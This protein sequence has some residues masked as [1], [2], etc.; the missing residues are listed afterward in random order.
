MGAPKGIPQHKVNQDAYTRIIKALMKEPQT[1][2]SLQELTGL[3]RVTLQRLFRT[4]RA[5][6]IV[7]ISDWEQDRRGA[8]AF[9][10]FTLGKGKDKP[11]YKM[12]QAERA[13][14]WRERKKLAAQVAH[15]DAFIQGN[16]DEIRSV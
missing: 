10:V 13:R 11:K 15:I 12:T 6:K 14:L 5:H 2:T 3:H 8:D 9:A 7:H 4:F 16:T 1:L